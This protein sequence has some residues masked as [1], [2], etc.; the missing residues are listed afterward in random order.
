MLLQ[1]TAQPLGRCLLRLRHGARLGR[2]DLCRLP[3]SPL[4]SALGHPIV[5]VCLQACSLFFKPLRPLPLLSQ[6]LLSSGHGL[7]HLAGMLLQR[8]VGGV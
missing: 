5:K 1:L 6:P 4:S 7:P 3:S 2:A 8:C